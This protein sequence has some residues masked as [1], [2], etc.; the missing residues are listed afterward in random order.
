[1]AKGRLR[2]YLGAAPGVGKTFAML[3]EGRRRDQRGTDVV[4][5]FVEAHG[6]PQTAAQVGDLEIVPRRRL[7]H[8]GVAFE[9]M[10][11]DAV[12]ARAPAVALVDEL[13]HTNVPG[14]RNPKRHQDVEEL[15][16]A[17]IDVISTLNIQHL[18]SLNDVVARITGITQKETV[19]DAVVRAAEQ[20]ELVDMTPEA[21]RRRMAHGNVYPA[22]RIDAALA[23]YFRPGNLGA[24]RELALLWVADRVEDALEDY[25]EAHD[26]TDPWETR[27]RVLV[28]LT[29]ALGG[30]DLIRRASR[31]ASRV[32]GN[33]LGVHVRVGTGLTEREPVGLESQR[34]LLAQLGGEYVEVAAED[35]A[36]GLLEVARA[37][38]CTQIVLGATRR[39]R[40]AEVVRGSVIASV[41]RGSGPIDVHVISTSPA[42][43]DDQ[44]ALPPAT[45]LV[46]LSTRRRV[47]GFAVA[48]VS[49][50]ALTALMLAFPE[51][52]TLSTALL[53]YLALAVMVAVVG[54][55]WPGLIA[56]AAG[57]ALGNW[58]FAEPVRQFTVLRRDDVIALVVFI[59]VA[60]TVSVL[61]DRNARFA[62]SARRA[63]AEAGALARLAGTILEVSDPLPRLVQDLRTAFRLRAAAVLRR[64][65]DGWTV[66]ASA[67][68]PVPRSPEDASDAIEL[69]GDDDEVLVVDG[70]RM[71]AD[72]RRLLAAFA[73][74]LAVAVD[75]RELTELASS[76]AALEQADALRTALLA[77][78]SHD[79]RTPLAGIKMTVTSLLAQDVEL[80]PAVRRELLEAVVEDTDRLNRLVGNLLDASRLSTGAVEL[81]LRPTGLDEVV[82]A[83]LAALGPRA[84]DVTVDVPETL[85]EVM[86]DPVLLERVVANLVE[87]AVKAS[88]GLPVRVAAGAVPDAV[89][90]AVRDLGPGI[91]P[92]D[93]ERIFQPFQ[94]LGDAPAGD[95]VGLGLAVA[96]GFTEA[97][98]GS[99]TVEDTPGGGTTMVV[100]LPLVVR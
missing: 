47:L 76:A 72:D 34:A 85:P 31:L 35:A 23:N 71:P 86:A 94:R 55:V 46:A 58:F 21:L 6:R 27:E 82:P 28:A 93:R 42:P 50:P 41:I 69:A 68:E 45:R 7:E 97:M 61:V 19:P 38:R 44:L 87:N 15:L 3:N 59:V 63:R 20:V 54:G 8:R 5:G 90:L 56:A 57:F 74:Q 75:R 18:E 77:A 13:A 33:L 9:E 29:G 91:P 70:G 78:V 84:L 96:R 16:A 49:Y 83:A 10:D 65:P 89:D 92:D 36:S 39:S 37:E 66:L 11:V 73:A 98:G 4:V 67:G 62:A 40:L 14:S 26:I 1:M 12:L 53:V 60:G 99:L 24:L 2:I 64:G 51:Q 88:R 25:L 81:L 100:R 95:G 17:G 79:L 43:D 48:A 52:L 80:E 22:D 30:E 32:S